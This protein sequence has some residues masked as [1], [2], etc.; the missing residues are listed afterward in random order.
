MADWISVDMTPGK[1]VPRPN[2]P[3]GVVQPKD[4]FQPDFTE[5]STAEDIARGFLRSMTAE[6]PPL[7]LVVSDADVPQVLQC[8]RISVGSRL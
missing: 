5:S 8:I 2:V 4:G 3:N 1:E 6:F 7:Q